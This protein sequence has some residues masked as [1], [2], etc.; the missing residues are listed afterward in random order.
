V[1]ADVRLAAALRPFTRR[2]LIVVFLREALLA[3]AAA[4]VAAEFAWVWSIR[5]LRLWTALAAAAML[6][7]AVRVRLNRPSDLTIARHIDRR[8]HLHDLVVTSLSCEGDGMG[9]AVRAR[10]MASLQRI[11]PKDVYPFDGPASWRR[12]LVGFVAAQAVVLPF[13]WQAPRIRARAESTSQVTGAAGA[14]SGADSRNNPSA[15][16]GRGLA[17]ATPAGVSSAAASPQVTGPVRAADEPVTG[18]AAASG[19]ATNALGR[20]MNRAAEDVALGRVPLSRRA[21]VQRYFAELSRQSAKQRSP[22]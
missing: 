5:D 7:V 10:A 9:A 3:F 16:F 20:A 22:R 19:P 18:S 1:P 21:L 15:S 13:A 8:A 12:W 6:F 4:A 17:P 11:R 2:A 14:D